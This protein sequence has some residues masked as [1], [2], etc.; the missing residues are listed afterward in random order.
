MDILL[1]DSIHY[2]NKPYRFLEVGQLNSLF[3]CQSCMQTK[4]KQDYE[5]NFAT[6]YAVISIKTTPFKC[7]KLKEVFT[8]FLNFEF[9]KK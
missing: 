7:I 3:Q 5:K 1:E 9:K 2:M 4:G 6:W 8:M